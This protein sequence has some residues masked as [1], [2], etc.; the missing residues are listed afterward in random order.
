MGI[1]VLPAAVPI[2]LLLRRI[3]IAFP[4]ESDPGVGAHMGKVWERWHRDLPTY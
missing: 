3:I 2:I 1:A 4:L